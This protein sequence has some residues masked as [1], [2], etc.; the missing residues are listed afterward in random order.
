MVVLVLSLIWEIW[1]SF[2]PAFRH[3][4]VDFSENQL[5]VY[6]SQLFVYIN[7]LILDDLS[8]YFSKIK[9]NRAI[10]LYRNSKITHFKLFWP[11]WSSAYTHTYIHTYLVPWLFINFT[12]ISLIFINENRK[13]SK[14]KL[15]KDLR[16]PPMSHSLGKQSTLIDSFSRKLIF[17]EILWDLEPRWHFINHHQILDF[18][19]ML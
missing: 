2:W 7:Q 13:F 1:T 15:S 12:L 18:F 16:E 17:F 9:I 10:L 5:F 3:Y 11:L 14:E 6:K 19:N 8:A 4:N